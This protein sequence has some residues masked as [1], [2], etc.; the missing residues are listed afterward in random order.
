MLFGQ[1]EEDEKSTMTKDT[2]NSESSLLSEITE[3]RARL[4]E[5]EDDTKSNVSSAVPGTEEWSNLLK[6]ELAKVE[7]EK[8]KMEM[9]YM[10]HMT[11]LAV[12][13]QKIVDDLSDRLKKSE[14]MNDILEERLAKQ[15]D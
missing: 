3:L 6:K 14:E 7:N 2:A 1:R 11:S 8:A 5:L 15:T 9:E 13:N 12:S 10:N 4:Q